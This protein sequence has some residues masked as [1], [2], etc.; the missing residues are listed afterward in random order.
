MRSLLLL[1]RKLVLYI[2][3]VLLSLSILQSLSVIPSLISLSR[4]LG[5][6]ILV[7]IHSDQA[8]GLT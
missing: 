3:A 7:Y 2:H 6:V 1:L 4:Y 5:P 8:L